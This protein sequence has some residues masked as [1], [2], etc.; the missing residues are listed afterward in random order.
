MAI[1][2]TVIFTADAPEA[3]GPYSQAIEVNGFVYASGQIPLHPETGEMQKGIKEQT[4]Q[5]FENIKAVMA[6]AGLTL[7]DIVKTAVFLT[8]MADF[9]PMNEVYASYFTGTFPAR[10]CVAVK[11]LPKGASVEIEVVAVKS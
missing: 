9:A 8:D 3:V 2:K 11:E 5:V 4:A 1:Q 7:D 10:S 6:A